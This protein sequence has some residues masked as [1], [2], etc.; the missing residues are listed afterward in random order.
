M[1]L[2]IGANGRTGRHLVKHLRAAGEPVIAMVR[3]PAQADRFEALG[4]SVHVHDLDE[5]FAPAFAGAHTV[6]YAAGSAEDQGEVEE[7]AYDRDA[8]I[9]SCDYARAASGVKR[10]VV[11][12]AL[13]AAAPDQATALRHYS[14]MKRASDDYVVASGMP[15]LIL[16]PG[17]LDDTPARHRVALVDGPIPVQPPVSREDVALLAVHA[18]AAGIE[19]RIIGFTGGDTPIEAALRQGS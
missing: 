19:N 18:L 9:R 11:I 16:R 4:A 8:V 1:Y 6:I 10:I 13:I 3:D 12:S 17:P 5:D 7:Q 15:Y 14:F 2:V